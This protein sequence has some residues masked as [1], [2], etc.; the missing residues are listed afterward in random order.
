MPLWRCSCL[1]DLTLYL[2]PPVPP[3]VS[4]CQTGQLWAPWETYPQQHPSLPQAPGKRGMS[5]SLRTC[6]ITSYTNCK[7]WRDATVWKF[8]L[9]TLS[10]L[11]MFQGFIF[12]ALFWRTVVEIARDIH[13]WK[14]CSS[15]AEYK[16]YSLPLTRQLWRTD[17]WR[18]W[19][20]MP[21]KLRETCMSQP[22]AE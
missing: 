7:C 11:F 3:P 6:A 10:W 12:K 1:K 19:W 20:P 5:T 17:E 4:C 2:F 13:C 14:F 9:D 8:L 16:P 21:E 18:T 15:V 22:T